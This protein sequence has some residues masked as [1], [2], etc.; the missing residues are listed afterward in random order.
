VAPTWDALEDFVA[1]KSIL[2]SRYAPWL[3]WFSKL[4]EMRKRWIS[5]HQD[6]FSLN[7][8]D[9]LYRLRAA[10]ELEAIRAICVPPQPE[11][12]SRSVR[13]I[14]VHVSSALDYAPAEVVAQFVSGI[15]NSF[16][17]TDHE[18]Y[19]FCEQNFCNGLRIR[20]GDIRP[21]PLAL[22]ILQLYAT[23]C[24]EGNKS[25]VL[26]YQNYASPDE[27]WVECL[28]SAIGGVLLSARDLGTL[29]KVIYSEVLCWLKHGPT[30]EC[31]DLEFDHLS[32][33]LGISGYQIVD[34]DNMLRSV[35]LIRFSDKTNEEDGF[36][37][38]AGP[39]E[40]KRP[41]YCTGPKNGLQA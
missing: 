1:I 24:R 5:I 15:M 6:G 27:I 39:M 30:R 41:R 22:Y 17:S 4:T 9:R 28:T 10:R 35:V 16:D 13:A 34:D 8:D 38:S 36:C 7:N 40:I 32:L 14:E 3:Q 25:N 23:W 33:L 37:L 29:L 11:T 21:V 18:H 31:F 12:S 2:V 20:A 19:R 26:W